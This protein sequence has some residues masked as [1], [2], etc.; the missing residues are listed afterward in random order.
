MHSVPG[1]ATAVASRPFPCMPTPMMPNRTRSLGAFMEKREG[2]VSGSSGMRFAASIALV[3]P[4]VVCKKDRREKFL[5]MVF[6]EPLWIL[7]L[8]QGLHADFFEK[9]D[10]VVAVILQADIALVGTTAALRLKIELARWNR[11]TLGVVG[12][13]FAIEFD[14]GMRAV[15]GNDHGVPVR[16]GLARFGERLG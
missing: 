5:R 15:E 4:A 13:F 7:C 1:R 3:A 12:D 2:M 8:L 16:P 11:L 10:V 9:D 6:S 14:D